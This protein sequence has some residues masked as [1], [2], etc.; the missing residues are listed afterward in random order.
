MLCRKVSLRF[1]AFI[2]TTTEYFPFDVSVRTIDVP[3]LARQIL[4]LARAGLVRR[5]VG[6]E[7][8]LENLQRRITDRQSHSELI[9]ELANTKGIDAVVERL[10]MRKKQNQPGAEHELFP[11]PLLLHND[12]DG[13]QTDRT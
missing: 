4:A 5:D 3:R 11:A 9:L 8:Y 1:L 6:E 10:A 13:H 2:A 12:R 7:A